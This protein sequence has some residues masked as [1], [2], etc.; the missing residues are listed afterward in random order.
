[1]SAPRTYLDYNATAPLRPEARAALLSALDCSG[2]PSSV[3]TE[4][5]RA[6][7]LVETAR[8]QVAAL[9]GAGAADVV[10]TSGATEAA[11]M[12]LR[13]SWRTMLFSR[14]EHPCVVAPVLAAEGRIV[15]IAVDHNGIIDVAALEVRFAE[16][17]AAGQLPAGQSLIA[18][19]MANNETGVLQPVSVI[20]NLARSYGVAVMCDAVQAAGRIAID[21]RTA[22]I[23]YLI[24]SSHKIGGPKGVGALLAL[25][26]GGLPPLIIGGGQ[27][28]RHRAGTE[29]VEGIAGF[30][31]AAVAAH[32]DLA[33]MARI[34]ALRDGI[35][36]ELR[37]TRGDVLIV[38]GL[39][40]R[41]ANT[42]SVGVP[43]VAAETLVIKL[44]LAGIAVS[45]GSACASGKVGSSPVL[46][47]MGI[48][49]ELARTVIRVSLGAAST[50][51]DA[52]KFVE[53]WR[54]AVS[55]SQATG[56]ARQRVVGSAIGFDEAA[57][58]A[59]SMGER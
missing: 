17:A 50:E 43:G 39:A 52:T 48:A 35:E 29:N 33:D 36:R 4:G 22:G 41:L 21:F 18:V 25:D 37:Q 6:R 27:E 20:A 57:P 14:I 32:R 7:A 38:A 55:P 28:R 13:R 40:P 3:H 9:V 45:A 30:G 16:L 8:E 2:N 19:Q 10:F 56:K 51:A 34:A 44:D 59:A 47:A 53:A 49:P 31:A 1:M 15:E 5:R 26:G 11:N 23:D 54:R 42:T 58:G 12:V 46:A 24:L